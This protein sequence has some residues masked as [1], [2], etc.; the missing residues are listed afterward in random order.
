MLGAGWL[1][2][3][4]RGALGRAYPRLVAANREPAW[5]LYELLLPTLGI[6]AFVYV[7][8]ALDAP[9]Q[10]T[11]FVILGG[12]AVAF[13]MNVMWSMAAQFYWE[14]QSANLE[15]YT[16]APCGLVPVLL[17]MALGS[18]IST[19]LRAGVIVAVGVL[20][21][22]AT[23]N[24][25]HWPLGLL[26]FLIA[27]IALY[28]M[29]ILLASL[30]LMWGRE[31]WHL[32]QMLQEPVYL[33][34]GFYFPVRALGLWVGM[35]A[36][37]VPL[38]LALDALRQLLFP[39]MTRGLLPLAWE[40]AGLGLLAVVFPLLALHALRFMERLARVEG[41]LTVRWQ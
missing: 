8:R 12:A 9:P 24:L 17:G 16:M 11:G 23:F 13:W 5:I 30:F 41:R 15:L 19:A 39:G 34:S 2:I 35:M 31:T 33:L 40:F 18:L 22:G 3:R 28:G 4:V 1:P 27:L 25:S 21:F 29:G 36:S 32:V 26:I 37:L 14:K 6:T 7:Y 38:T 10:F 20:L